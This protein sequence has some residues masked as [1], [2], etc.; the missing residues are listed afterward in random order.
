MHQT[1]SQIS[2]ELDQLAAALKSALGSNEPF[3]VAHN[4]WSFPGL[5]RDELASRIIAISMLIK[6]RATDQEPSNNKLLADYPRRIAYLRSA[7]LPNLWGNPSVGVPAFLVTLE[8]LEAALM[9]GLPAAGESA[10]EAL[11][12]AAK[13][14]RRAIERLRGIEGRLSEIEPRQENLAKMI[15]EIESAHEAAGQLPTDL[16]TLRDIRED[17]AKLATQSQEDRRNLGQLL[18]AATQ[19][20]AT[21]QELANEAKKIVEQC[22]SAYA[23]TTSQGLAAAFT[24]RSSRLATTTWVWVAGLVA[25]LLVGSALGSRQLRTLSDAIN[26]SNLNWGYVIV[27]AF[28]ALLSIGAPVWFAWLATKQIGQRFRLTEDYGFKASISRA[29][30]GYRREAVRIDAALEARLFSSALSRLDEHPLRLVEPTSHGSPWHE[31]ASSDLVRKAADVIPGFADKVIGLAKEALAAVK[32]TA[33][34]ETP[35]EDKPTQKP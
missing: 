17:V 32:P 12:E 21:L 4:N 25:A 11:A 7:T 14:S 31:L 26:I 3:S 35:S 33:K 5:T 34:V 27:D 2:A 10:N 24:E 29:Y 22:H 1:M 15:A 20:R 6:E 19:D 28:L 18:E 9:E 13:G 23:A 8:G 30:E 16:Q